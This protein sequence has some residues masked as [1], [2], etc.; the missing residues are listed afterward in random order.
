MLD[1]SNEESVGIVKPQVARFSNRLDL[2]CGKSISDISLTYETYGK[3]SR[4]L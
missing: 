2:D 4:F 1:E 3:K